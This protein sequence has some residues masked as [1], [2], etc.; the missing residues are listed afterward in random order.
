MKHAKELELGILLHRPDNKPQTPTELRGMG[1][2]GK[3]AS[4]KFT[5]HGDYY[6]L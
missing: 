2:I 5:T 3:M 6:D 1:I 4:I